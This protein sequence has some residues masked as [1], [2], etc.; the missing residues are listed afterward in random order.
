M[1]TMRQKMAFDNLLENKGSVSQAMRDAGYPRTTAKN[2]QQLTESKGW[3]ELLEQYLPDSLLTKV[4]VEG[5]G[6]TKYESRLTGKG[7]SEI[8]E[9]A[10][11]SVRHK[12]LET[13]LKVKG[14]Y[15]DPGT[16]NILVINVSGQSQGRYGTKE[17]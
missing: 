8:V 4:H 2:P 7:E 10:D 9:V 5:L 11:F 12:Y 15:T 6:A 13:G 14:K 17:L 16:N 3:A 1:A